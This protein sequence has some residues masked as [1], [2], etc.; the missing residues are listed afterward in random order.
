MVCFYLAISLITSA[1][2]NG[3][4]ARIQVAEREW[5]SDAAIVIHPR[6]V[7]EPGRAAGAAAPACT[8]ARCSRARSKNRATIVSIVIIVAMA[9]RP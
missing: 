8:R 1:L 2:R 3:T 6:A 5:R 9:W 4:Y 7:V